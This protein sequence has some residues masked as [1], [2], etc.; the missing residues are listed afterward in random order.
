[1]GDNGKMKLMTKDE[2][3]KFNPEIRDREKNAV[4]CLVLSEHDGWQ[5]GTN[6]KDYRYIKVDLTNERVSQRFDNA[7]GKIQM[8]SKK[9]VRDTNPTYSYKQGEEFKWIP[10][11]VNGLVSSLNPHV[12]KVFK[13]KN[14]TEYDINSSSL[15][16][17]TAM[18]KSDTENPY[19]VLNE[20]AQSQGKEEVELISALKDSNYDLY[21][22]LLKGFGA[23]EKELRILAENAARIRMGYLLYG[24]RL[25]K[26][27]E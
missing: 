9:A 21:Y 23:S 12:E 3:S 16:M 2:L 27:T 8:D 7:M 13:Q 14:H 22:E 15:L 6:P 18:M 26:T 5:L 4:M 1:M 11:N 20:F 10:E 19:L 17:A 24:D 25:P